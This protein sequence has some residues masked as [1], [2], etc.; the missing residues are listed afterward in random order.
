MLASWKESYD[1]SRQR[2]KKQSH[3]F[4]NKSLYN[5]SY[6]FSSKMYGYEIWT[7]KNW[8]IYAFNL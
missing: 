1:K 5:Q 8:R 2:I 7:M 4:A 6:G 3:H